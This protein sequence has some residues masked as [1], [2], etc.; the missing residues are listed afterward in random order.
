MHLYQNKRRRAGNWALF[1]GIFLF[2]VLLLWIA[3]SKIEK[4][5][6]QERQD[7]LA[8]AI[9]QAVVSC[10]AIEGRYP[11]DL[12]Y[13]IENYGIQYDSSEYMVTYEIFAD[14]ISPD[15]RIVRLGD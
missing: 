1:A 8:E 6:R 13:L 4:T 15:V 14:N 9:R 7:L 12:D 10:Y 3:A 5:T 11:Q 2:A